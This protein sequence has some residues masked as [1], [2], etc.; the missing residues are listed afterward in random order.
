MQLRQ[1]V[2]P[3]EFADDLSFSHQIAEV[4]RQRLY[5]SARFGLDF[6]LPHRL[7]LSR[8]D[9]RSRE[10]DPLY[11]CDLIRVDLVRLPADRLHGIERDR[12]Q[13]DGRGHPQPSPAFYSLSHVFLLIRHDRPGGSDYFTDPVG[14]SGAMMGRYGRDIRASAAAD[15]APGR[16][17]TFS[18]DGWPIRQGTAFASSPANG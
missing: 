6:D 10:V 3:V 14:K 8:S 13:Y 17:E 5:H 11:G 16:R 7:Y 2:V 4:D 12:P 9:D 15:H 18:I 1:Q